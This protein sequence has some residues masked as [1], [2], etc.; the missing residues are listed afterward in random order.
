MRIIEKHPAVAPLQKTVE[1]LSRLREFLDVEIE[2][3]LSSRNA[4]EMAWREALRLYEGVPKNPVRNTPVENAPNIEVTLGAIAADEIYA[5]AIDLMFQVSPIITVRAVPGDGKARVPA[6]K[7]LQDFA[8]WGIV[9]EWGLRAAADHA[10]LD[11]VQ[12]GT[13]FYYIPFIEQR[14]KTRV[15]TA[16]ARSPMICSQPVEDL[17]VPGGS[18]GQLQL[19]RWMALRFWYTKGEIEE[20]A[21]AEE[22]DISKVQP[23]GTVGW[24]RSRREVLGRTWSS[25][26][27][28]VLYEVY[29]VYVYFDIDGDGVEE[30]LLVVWDR[31]S[32][33]ILKVQYNPYDIRPAEEMRYQLR[34]HLF[35]GLGVIDMLRPFQ[36]EATELHNSRTLNVMLANARMWKAK[37]GAVPDT[38]RVWAGKVNF[39]DNMDDLD[40]L[41]M[42][43]VYPSAAMAQQL[44]MQLAER[45]VG[46]LGM[47]SPRPSQI[48]GSRTPGITALSMLQQVNRRFTPAFDGMRIGAARAVRQC[49]YRYQERLLAGDLQLEG[50]LRNVVGNESGNVLVKLL[51]DPDFDEAINVEITAS[52][53][54]VNREADRQNAMMLTSIL[55]SYYQ[56]TLEL[57][58]IAA[59]PMTPAPVRDVAKKIAES[60]GAIIE[61]TIRTFDQVRDPE[62]FI[63]TIEN[64]LDGNPALEQSGLAGLAQLIAGMSQS[65]NG[66]EGAAPALGPGGQGG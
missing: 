36:E 33:T 50:H 54:S 42:A 58:T 5:Q 19:T 43:E 38:F 40:A 32:R 62:A 24:V 27:F 44:T 46:V 41:Q 2:D 8:N 25:R 1:G 47:S 26:Q 15:Y 6:A 35:Y 4:Q 66:G 61:R 16:T 37:R 20:R 48:M 22:L 9:N 7:I 64:E 52:S 17:L 10:L 28:N 51:R 39:L 30:D 63:I 3:A 23:C 11:D 31:T 59:N 29:R 65:Q 18:Y 14:K 13:G 21:A 60:A 49:L 12:L 57:V 56:R 55:A 34:G 45:R 53:V